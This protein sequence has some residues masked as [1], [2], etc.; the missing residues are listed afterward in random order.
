VRDLG[1]EHSPRIGVA[2][3]IAAI[4]LL[5]AMAALVYFSRDALERII[6]PGGPDSAS[7]AAAV[8]SA[9]VRILPVSVN[10][11]TVDMGGR[12]I[13]YD[14]VRLSRSRS[15]L[16]ANLEITRWVENAGGDIIYGIESYDESGRRQF[17]TLGI[18]RGDSLI[19]EIKI[20][21]RVR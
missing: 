1:K 5:A 19:Q 16:R 10:T 17:L 15:V 4:A 9:Y 11:G 14:Y 21:K 2:R 8:E 18:G 3:L 7:V 12:R 20:E 13:R 6:P